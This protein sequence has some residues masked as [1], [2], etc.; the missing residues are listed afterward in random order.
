[1]CTCESKLKNLYILFLC[2]VL[3]VRCFFF[4]YPTSNSLVRI[5]SYRSIH[6]DLLSFL[7]FPHHSESVF[8]SIFSASTK[9]CAL[10]AMLLNSIL[11]SCLVGRRDD[12]A[13]MIISRNM[14]FIVLINR[15]S[16]EPELCE[17]VL[18]ASHQRV[19]LWSLCQYW[20]HRIWG[21][22]ESVP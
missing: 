12:L 1:M 18:F 7:L 22:K 6:H 9:S 16:P 5:S 14:I 4:L 15:T 21:V 2:S 8:I 19:D 3:C 11:R 13:A 20:R 10:C 17:C